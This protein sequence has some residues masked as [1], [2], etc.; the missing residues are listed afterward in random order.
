MP[1]LLGGQV[2]MAFPAL[3]GVISQIKSGQIDRAGRH[4]ASAFAFSGRSDH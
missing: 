3:S 1:D 4:V 2:Q